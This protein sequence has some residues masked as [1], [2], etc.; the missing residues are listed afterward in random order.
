MRLR[1]RTTAPVLLTAALLLGACG[2]TSGGT[3][4]SSSAAATTFTTADPV[5]SIAPVDTAA[6]RAYAAFGED[7]VE[8]AYDETV[9]LA[10][11]HYVDA[12]TLL[13]EGPGDHTPDQLA[14]ATADATPSFAATWQAAASRYLG[15][16]PGATPA[17]GATVWG[18]AL[19]DLAPADP[20][21]RWALPA[22]GALVTRQY[23][24]NPVFTP[25]A[26]GALLVRFDHRLVLGLQSGDAPTALQVFRTVTFRLLP[27]PAGSA[28]PWQVD[29]VE[30]AGLSVTPNV[31]GTPGADLSRVATA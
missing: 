5:V 8:A 16:T 14:A 26:D 27:A 4:A 9:E 15:Q 3:A 28:T 11:R 20:S 23:V 10:T 22:D 7:Q 30:V 17:D 2:G 24:R 18:L 13:D 19:T 25:T 6:Q 29:G 21:A 12:A 31:P 1:A